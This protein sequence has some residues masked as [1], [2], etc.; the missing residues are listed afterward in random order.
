MAEERKL[1]RRAFLGGAAAIGGAAALSGLAACSPSGGEAP[2][3]GGGEAPAGGGGGGEA[4]ATDWLGTAPEIAE[5]DITAFVDTDV[6]VVGSAMAGVLAAYAAIKNGAR[7][8]M[9][10]RNGSPHISGSGVGFFNSQFQQEGG[11]PV[12][13][14]QHVMS[15]V[16]N[17]GNLRVDA[18]LV[19]L[20]AYHSGEI[21]D[22][23]EADVLQPAGLPGRIMTG[24]A[25][26]P[27]D[28]D[29]YIVSFHV[30]FDPNE[31]DSLEAFI[32][33][34]HDWVVANG[35]E[36][37]FETCARKL[38]QDESGAVTGAICTNA[39]GAYVQYNTSKGVIM[40][41]GS[42][43]GNEAMVNHFCYPTMAHFVNTYN[44]YNAKA[45]DTAPV[46]IEEKMDDGI[47]HRM[48]VWAGGIM[49]EIDPSYQ[50]WSIDG[51]SF[52]APL[53]VNNQGNRFFN[54]TFSSLS[55]SFPIFELPDGA[56]YV[57]QI[58]ASDDFNMPPL[59]P[60]PG[61]TREIMDMIASMSEFY[62]ADT[63]EEL[64]DLIKVPAE[65]LVATVN[66]YNELAKAGKD[67][68]FGKA[69][70]HMSPIEQPPFKAFRENY[71]FYGM[72]SGVKVNRNLEVVDKDWKPIP[73][74]YAAGNCVGWR[75]GSGYQNVVPGLCNAYSAVHAY[76][77]GKNAAL[78]A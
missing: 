16:I 15:Q 72:S 69:P 51:Y 46:T 66:R 48:M 59:L 47:G 70:W 19:A 36:V 1:S 44:A 5:A 49:E 24:E 64:A 31:K 20:W 33:A 10:E 35:G 43:G 54:E 40:C 27:D 26:H 34:F 53:A 23:I 28:L 2:A 50:A 71:A 61:M 76:F 41:A 6:L 9:I 32:F 22:E 57:W 7:V 3:A 39:E 60:I 42:Y 75:M 14:E 12:H 21:L 55:T 74:L 37:L 73:G 8:V 58:V 62:E 67:D 56:N 52:A 63:L 18:S 45:S 4:A 68:D 38:V 25:L 30:D 11:Q 17:E 77:A 65:N 13:N 29:Q 78:R